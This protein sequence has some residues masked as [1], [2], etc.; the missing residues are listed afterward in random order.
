MMDLHFVVFLSFIFLFFSQNLEIKCI[1]F[2]EELTTDFA[3]K[4]LS[5][6]SCLSIFVQGK[7]EYLDGN[8]CTVN[9]GL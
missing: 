9:D 2:L 6:P 3:H 4:S 8:L 7:D 5:F 1:C